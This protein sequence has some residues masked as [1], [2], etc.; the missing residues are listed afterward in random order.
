MF[1]RAILVWLGTFGMVLAILM[2]SGLALGQQYPTK[3][4]RVIIPF[5]AGGSAD[6]IGRVVSQKLSEFLGQPFIA[7]N[8]DGAGGRI[9]IE[10]ASK[11]KPDGYTLALGNLSTLCI[12]PNLYAALRYDPRSFEPISML[13]IAPSVLVVHP[14]VQATV[15]RELIDLEKSKSGK[16]NFA[17]VGIGTVPHFAGVHFNAETGT[18]F[19]HVPFKG[20]APALIALLSGEVQLMIDQLASL[21]LPNIQSGKLRALAVTS[22]TRLRQL[23]DVP[24][25]VEA[26]FSELDEAVWFGLIAPAGT[27]KEVIRIVNEKVQMAL[28]A[29]GVI[30]SLVNNNALVLVGGSAEQFSATI[31]NDMAKWSRLVKAS[32][33]TPE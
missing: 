27:P 20:A 8:R 21:Q 10:A 18:R 24:T 31:K 25:M 5:P 19:V 11:A 7:D 28:A 33:F 32:G 16:M 17:S 13:T 23:P 4:I 1:Q 14:S 29:K 6:L 26:G 3:P 15:L 30:D 9:G 2:G 12:A 22:S